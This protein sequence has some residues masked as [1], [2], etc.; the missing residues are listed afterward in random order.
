MGSNFAMVYACLFLYHLED[1][2]NLTSNPSLLYLKRYIDDAFGIWI[3]PTH[4]LVNLLEH[5]GSPLKEHIKITPCISQ[6]SIT[7]LDTVFFKGPRFQ[8]LEVLDSHCYQKPLNAFHW[9][10]WHP[11][12]Q[13]LSF[14]LAELKRYIIQESSLKGFM[15]L[16]NLLY[17]CL[18]AKGYPSLP[19]LPLL[20]K[21]FL[22]YLIYSPHQISPPSR[23]NPFKPLSHAV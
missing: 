4:S 23:Q 15:K 8:A 9:N 18:R 7:I 3:G 1:S 14:I 2:L 20:L 21:L 5:Y 17:H 12:Q 19:L 11:T 22:T 10:S 16:C 13:K 6:S